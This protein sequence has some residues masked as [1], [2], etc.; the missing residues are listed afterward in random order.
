MMDIGA[1]TQAM[2]QIGTFAPTAPTSGGVTSSA[3]LDKVASAMKIT[4][5]KTGG[6][7]ETQSLTLEERLKERYPNLVYHVFDGSNRYWQTRNDFPF[8]KIYQQGTKAEEIENW[9]PS[10]PNPDP[11]SSGAQRMIS[12]IPVGSKA[13]IIHPK[14]QER[15][16]QDPEYAD[17]IYS[18][19][20]A[21]FTFDTA[22][23]EAMIPGIAARS[24]QCLAIGEDGNI[25]NVMS[26]SKGEITQSKS[27]SDDD[28]DDFWTARTKR[29][30]QYMKLVVEAQILHA[31][32]ISKQINLWS[33][34]ESQNSNSESSAGSFSMTQQF[35]AMQASQSALS[36]TMSMINSAEFR[37]ALG[38]TVAGVPIDTVFDNTKKSIAD[39]HPAMML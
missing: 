36:E 20:E 32:G 30:H 31:Q 16:E 26:C 19:I 18:R 11:V 33:L 2:S 39:F 8:Y 4:Q 37:Q 24:S 29:F 23:N 27:G 1:L 35:K 28:E 25:C 34:T 9:E 38:D 5:Q 17:E 6:L 22:R 15:M 7:S 12:S 10:G 14:V 21:W 3:F 13:V